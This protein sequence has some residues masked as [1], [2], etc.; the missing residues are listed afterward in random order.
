MAELEIE[1]LCL[2]ESQMSYASESSWRCSQKS[3]Y[4]DM[5]G[6]DKQAERAARHHL[7]TMES[8][9]ISDENDGGYQVCV[10]VIRSGWCPWPCKVG[11]SGVIYLI[12]AL[13]AGLPAAFSSPGLCKSGYTL[14][15]VIIVYFPI[16]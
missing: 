14:H 5:R 9:V 2:G 6:G 8:P 16:V 4:L 7:M 3:H 11:L 15:A 10:C 12:P 1:K 13:P